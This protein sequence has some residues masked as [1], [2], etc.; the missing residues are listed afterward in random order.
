MTRTIAIALAVLL[1]AACP[2]VAKEKYAEKINWLSLS[3]GLKKAKAEGKPMIVDFGVP[4]GCPRCA[5][6]EKNVY[7]SDEIAGKINSEFVPVLIDL[8]KKLTPEEK[9]L[10]EAYDF[11]ND[12]LLLFL[13]P[14]GRVIKDPMGVSMCFA[15]NVEPKVFMDYLDYVKKKYVPVGK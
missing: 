15:D 4:E 14:D 10:G 7:G 9:A 3:A 13:D 6:L 1:F 2:A 12:C 5:F 8:S 11:K